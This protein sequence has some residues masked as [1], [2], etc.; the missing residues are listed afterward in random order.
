VVGALSDEKQSDPL[1]LLTGGPGDAPS[2][3][4]SFFSRVF[5]K[6]R[7][8]RDLVLVDLRGTGKSNPLTCPELGEP[9][10]GGFLDENILSILKVEACR[11]RLKTT[12][13][14]QQYTTE[15]AVDDLDEVRQALG[16]RKINLYGTSYGTR[17]AQVYMR[18][19]PASIRSVS[20]KGI[21]PPSMASPETHARASE[22]A[23]KTLLKRC[24]TDETCRKEFPSPEADLRTML[25]RLQDSPVLS[26][27]GSEDPRLKI[28]VTPGL[29]GEV[30]RFFLYSPET[31]ARGLTLL[32]DITHT[33]KPGLIENVLGGRRLLSG[34]RLAAGF[35]LSVSCTEDVPYLPK[36]VAPLV[37]GTFG[38]DYSLRQQIDACA[39]WPKGKVSK[40]HRKPTDS[41]IPSL[42]LS[43]EFD[44]VTPPAGAEGVLHG[45]RNGLHVVIKNNGHPMGNAEQCVG[46]MIGA[47]IEKGDVKG[48]NTSCAATI[49]AVPLVVGAAK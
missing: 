24:Q 42:L 8:H 46:S 9:N 28:K 4:A 18:R 30:F 16:Y 45:L 25:T 32:R 7:Q 2:F 31:E 1:F 35:F 26:M 49:P 17:V 34:N 10:A 22:D 11:D 38:G 3:N 48:L 36:D 13:D 47:F 29:F 23:W 20:L 40:D 41:L 15:T 37:A 27:P 21:V 43:G 33:D 6:L 44:P 5:A 39:V 12:S 19:H 14:L